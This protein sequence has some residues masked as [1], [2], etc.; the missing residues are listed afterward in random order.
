MAVIYVKQNDT[1]PD[2]LATILDD[3]GDVINLTDATVAFHMNTSVGV[4][5][6]ESAGKLV[7]ASEGTVKYEWAVGDLD[8]VGT[9]TAEFQITFSDASVLTAPNSGY[10]TI[11]VIAELN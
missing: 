2:I 4:S 6:V 3:D 5:K 8:T 9:Y 11:V 7:V 1:K 10:M